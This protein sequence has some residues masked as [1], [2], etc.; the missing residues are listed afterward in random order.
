M[1][2]ELEPEPLRTDSRF[3][4]AIVQKAVALAQRME[5]ERRET[6]SLDEVKQLAE[7]L[8]LDPQILQQALTRVSA[9][10]A[11]AVL[12]Q[13]VE[14]HAP[15]LRQQQRA[16][17]ILPIAALLGLSLLL[18][19]LEVVSRARRALIAPPVREATE[20]RADNQVANGALTALPG[21]TGALPVG[22]RALP[23]WS[24]IGEGVTV[25]T[26]GG[27]DGTGY[28]RL[29][30]RGGIRQV[31]TTTPGQNYRLQ[32][33]LSGAPSNVQEFH[34]IKLRAGNVTTGL[35]TFYSTPPGA[36]P[37]W[38][39]ET[40]PFQALTD[41]SVI[42]ISANLGPQNVAEPYIDSITV[43]PQ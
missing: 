19:S 23:G 12:P 29:G 34:R 40:M 2:V 27:A 3:R 6:L 14:R 28:L 32:I 8:N 20:V 17:V 9:E 35:G 22:S 39:I 30:R 16:T 18:G 13:T 25:V 7:E 41:R 15:E 5:Q 42:E 37:N 36:H 11:Q 43:T 10:E 24:I 1:R 26:R 4:A 33:H 38:A 31:F 21:Q